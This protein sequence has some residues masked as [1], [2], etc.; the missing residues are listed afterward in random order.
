MNAA[1]DDDDDDDDD[2]DP[3]CFRFWNSHFM[4]FVIQ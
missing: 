3:G 2:D 1:I 4:G